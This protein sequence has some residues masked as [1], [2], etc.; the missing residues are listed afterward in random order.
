MP[1][2]NRLTRKERRA[3]RVESRNLEWREL[4]ARLENLDRAEYDLRYDLAWQ[5][6][7]KPYRFSFSWSRATIDPRSLRGLRSAV[8]YK[9]RTIGHLTERIEMLRKSLKISGA[10][11]A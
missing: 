6:A 10:D 7:G 11:D 3:Q 9:E 5:N 4:E 1:D 2:L 8:T